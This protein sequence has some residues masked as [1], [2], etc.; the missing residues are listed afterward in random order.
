MELWFAGSGILENDLRNKARCLGLADR[1]RFTG[2]VPHPASFYKAADLV[3]LTSRAEG[4]PLALL[5]AMALG[6]PVAATR[7][8][9]VEDLLD[10]CG[11]LLDPEAGT[12]EW[13][14]VIAEV[15][16]DETLRV[17]RTREAL[18]MVARRHQAATLLDAVAA[19]YAEVVAAQERE[20]S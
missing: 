16:H 10:G 12:G 13:A 8:G 15:L 3:L 11:E 20:G 7:V 5:E 6:V 14:R 1:V 19:L 2:L 9:G 18:E 17:S 4:T